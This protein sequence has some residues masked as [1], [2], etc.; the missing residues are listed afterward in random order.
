MHV[1]IVT[2]FVSNVNSFRDVQ[3]YIDN[4]KCLLEIETVNKIVFIEQHIYDTYF[5]NNMFKNIHFVFIKFNDLYISQ[6]KHKITKFSIETTNNI[7]DT[8]DYMIVQCHKTEWL[9]QAIELDPFQSDNFIWIDFGIKHVIND[10]KISEYICNMTK[11]QFVDK[12]RIAGCWDINA[13]YH[14]SI[15]KKIMW[16]FAGGVFGG[17]KE[18]MLHFASLMREMCLRIIN[19]D[20]TITW[21]VNI[22]YLIYI[23]NKEMFDIYEA[24]HNSSILCNY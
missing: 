21:E 14:N 9:R 13:Y 6:E 16:Y 8:I 23:N 1:S 22:W 10:D 2:A 20:N 19:E 5:K 3:K 18:I 12:I 17:S 11:K 24:N 7:K 4:G 15:Y